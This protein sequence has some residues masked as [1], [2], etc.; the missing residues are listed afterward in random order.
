MAFISFA[1][2]TRATIL[3]SRS[4]DTFFIG[5]S[6]RLFIDRVGLKSLTERLMRLQEIT[7]RLDPVGLMV[8]PMI[9]IA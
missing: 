1:I 6:N 2:F 7:L 3:S 5:I 9:L 4:E 8:F